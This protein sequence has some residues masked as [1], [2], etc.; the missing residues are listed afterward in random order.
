MPTKLAAI[1]KNVGLELEYRRMLY[2]LLDE[3]DKSITYWVTSRYKSAMAQDTATVA[4][5]NE[6]IRRL[7][8]KWRK[9]FASVAP[10]FAKYFSTAVKDRTDSS[11]KR[12]LKKS[13]VTVAFKPT[14]KIK[15]I[16]S[17]AAA[18][19]VSLIKTIATEHL[20]D[21][22]Q[23][24][25][26][27]V[28]AGRDLGGLRADL[29]KRYTITKR[30]AALIARQSNN[31]VSS[32]VL[33]ARQEEL[34]IT[35]AVWHH[36]HAGKHPRPEHMKWHL[37]KYNVQ[38]GKWSEHDQEWQWPGTAFNCRCSERS[39]LPVLGVVRPSKEKPKIEGLKSY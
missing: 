13:G 37:T 28:T 9:K 14:P 38:T 25:M 4:S 18:E 6:I 30:R 12:A 5:L 29:Q 22:G 7:T 10:D 21:V 1:N 34:G 16:M 39:I 15:D 32:A 3:M 24:V 33:R 31:N 27:S 23:M 11:L 26:Q 35:E 2:K 36:S 8:T 20:S 19:N 17:A